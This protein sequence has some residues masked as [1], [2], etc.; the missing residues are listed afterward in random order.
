MKELGISTSRIRFFVIALVLSLSAGGLFAASKFM[1][2]AHAQSDE[3]TPA[4]L[5]ELDA[6]NRASAAGP[7]LIVC[8]TEVETLSCSR[9]DPPDEAAA[10]KAGQPLFIRTIRS[11]VSRAIGAGVPVLESDELVC[12]DPVETMQCVAASAAPPK[13]PVGQ[14]LLV[15]YKRYE[16]TVSSDGTL[17]LRMG[18]PQ[19]PLDAAP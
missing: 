4:A 12:G 13:L 1:R 19:V 9:V 2:A 7:A 11:D 18:T 14:K 5:D 8:N 10:I 15:T 3:L 16:P 17:T 6:M